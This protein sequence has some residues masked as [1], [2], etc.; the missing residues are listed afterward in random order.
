VFAPTLEMGTGRMV[1]SIGVKFKVQTKHYDVPNAYVNADAEEGI[2]IYTEFPPGIQVD[3][4]TLRKFG[5]QHQ[6]QLALILKKSLY[7]LKQ[8]GRMWNKKLDKFLKDNG[9]KA[10]VTDRCLYYKHG[11]NGLTIVGVYVD[12]LLV[13]GTTQD[14]AMSFQH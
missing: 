13:T 9:F 2:T 7:D 8:A 5:V 6:N 12:D 3:E 10:S 11:D 1:I 4:E 14:A